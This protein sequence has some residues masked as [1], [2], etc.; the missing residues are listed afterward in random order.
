MPAAKSHELL[1]RHWKAKQG[2]NKRLS[3]RYL[4][5]KLDISPPYL[6]KLLSGQK[7]LPMHRLRAIAKELE[8]DPAAVRAL[9]RAVLREQH[10]DED[11]RE[12]IELEVPGGESALG[13]L[14]SSGFEI[15]PSYTALEE[16]YYLPILELI[17]LEGFEPSWIPVR[18]GLQP[19]VAEAAWK[20]LLDLG[21]VKFN[22]EK[23]WWE[24]SAN[25]I[26]FPAARLDPAIQ[27]HHTKMLQKAADELARRRT[28][29]DFRR[30]L[31]LGASV[32]TSEAGFRKAEKFLEE[33]LFKAV[34]IMG[35]ARA[36]SPDR[37]Y[38]VSLQLF[39][40]SKTN[41]KA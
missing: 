28:E 32:A 6:S 20:R 5:R 4:A 18:L 41:S 2:R 8:L 21:W 24:K 29:E 13:E 26:R 16:W 30:R 10:Q 11:L 12:N 39:P 31:I 33:A 14:P 35:S 15:A 36:G 22:E 7:P 1:L 17:T 27:R 37:V 25:R 19:S 3:L 38:Y 34:E 23:G 9:E 40:L